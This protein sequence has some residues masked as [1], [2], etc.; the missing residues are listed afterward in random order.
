VREALGADYSA[1]EE[2]KADVLGLYMVTQLFDKKELEGSLDDY[3][4]TFVASV[5]RSV[6]FG[7]ASAHGKANMITFNTLLQRGA[8]VVE[9][10]GKAQEDGGAEKRWYKVDVEKMRQ[11]ISDLAAE[12]LILQGNGDMTAVTA[13]LDGRGVIGAPLQMDIK[14][15]ETAGIPVDLVFDQGIETLGLSKFYKPLPEMKMQN[16]GGKG[17]PGMGGPGQ[18]GPGGIGGPGGMGGPG[19]GGPGGM[20]APG[21]P[22]IPGQGGPGGQM[23]PPP[24]LPKK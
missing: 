9:E 13:M 10:K 12:L 11:V 19:Q 16:M 6:R 24:P 23:P 3:Y 18:G 7:A 15:L 8:I 21:Q 1:I 17:K 5:F 20:G 2:C 22:N 14:R 4:V